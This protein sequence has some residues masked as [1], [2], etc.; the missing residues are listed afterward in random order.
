MT[1]SS[2]EEGMTYLEI[3]DNSDTIKEELLEIKRQTLN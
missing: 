3:T 2:F 1:I